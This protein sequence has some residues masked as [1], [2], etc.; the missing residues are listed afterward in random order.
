[1]SSKIG[2]ATGGVRHD[3]PLGTGT[4]VNDD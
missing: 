4:I 1:M 3:D 2:T